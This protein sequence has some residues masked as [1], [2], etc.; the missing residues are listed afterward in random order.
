MYDLHKNSAKSRRLDK[1]S[2]KELLKT[3]TGLID[4]GLTT[5]W[6]LK[7]KNTLEIN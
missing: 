2:S 7:N 6:S 5:F 3:A 4:F 1:K